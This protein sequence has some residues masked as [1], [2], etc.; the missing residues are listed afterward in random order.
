MFRPFQLPDVR[1]KSWTDLFKITER[2]GST[3]RVQNDRTWSEP[4]DGR[5]ADP[6]YV[7][8]LVV[9]KCDDW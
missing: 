5:V 6:E 9:I 1:V 4:A 7:D 8:G 2:L 3:F